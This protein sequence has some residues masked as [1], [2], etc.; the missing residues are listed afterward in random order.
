MLSNGC[1]IHKMILD[2][3]L[4]R[5]QPR[6]AGQDLQSYNNMPQ[7]LTAAPWVAG[8]KAAMPCQ[9]SSR[10]CRKDEDR[11]PIPFSDLM[12]LT[13]FLHCFDDVGWVASGL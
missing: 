11:A 4:C 5:I 12:P 8:T 13:D 1:D 6:S 3:Q 10:K 2:K 7:T 9:K